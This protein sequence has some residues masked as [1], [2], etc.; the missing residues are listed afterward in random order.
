M[1]EV[2]GLGHVGL[3]PE[4]D[5]ALIQA[6]ATLYKWI[7]VSLPS[8]HSTSAWDSPEPSTDS[9]HSSQFITQRSLWDGHST[10]KDRYRVK[11]GSRWSKIGSEKRGY[12]V[13]RVSAR[14]AA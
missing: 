8:I 3:D 9:F 1:R 4:T 11:Y 14:V 13:K 12:L 6:R 7:K 5:A 2:L 10:K